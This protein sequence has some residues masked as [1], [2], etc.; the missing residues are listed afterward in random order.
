MINK[1]IIF[2]SL[3]FF[4]WMLVFAYQVFVVHY[5]ALHVYPFDLTLYLFIYTIFGLG[6]TLIMRFF[7]RKSF[8]RNSNFRQVITIIISSSFIG[9]NL[10]FLGVIFLDY[11]LLTLISNLSTTGITL[12]YYMWEIFHG[13]LIYSVWGAIYFAVKYVIK[14]KEETTKTENAELLAK[15]SQLQ[16]LRYQLNPHFLFNALSS[17]RALIREDQNKAEEMI[18]KIGDFLRFSLSNRPAN[19]Y[20]LIEEIEAIKNY[21]EIEKVRFDNKLEINFDIDSLA[22]DFPIPSFL[23]HPIFENAIK[24]GMKTSE[25]PLT[26]SMIAQVNE[27]CLHLIISN[28]GYWIEENKTDNI[29]GTGNG[30]KNIRSRLEHRFPNRHSF[31]I[32]K[33]DNEVRIEIKVEQNPVPSNEK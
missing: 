10:L 8:S 20:P 18:T 15:S 32:N 13:L 21:L 16:M 22:E 30:I 31:V 26:I 2:W 3:Q 25:M 12:R 33:S 9:A 14:L 28:S 11:F 24:Y 27:T 5:Q 1:N 29:S 19:D 4:G 7:F 17:L 6:I 23:L